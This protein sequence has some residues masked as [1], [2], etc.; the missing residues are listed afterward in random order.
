VD[1][2]VRNMVKVAKRSK[3]L[4]RRPGLAIRNVGSNC[5]YCNHQTECLH[6]WD[7]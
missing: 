2:A 6:P 1:L 5:T 7:A 3:F 4:L